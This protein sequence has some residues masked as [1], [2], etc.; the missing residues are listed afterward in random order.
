M[1]PTVTDRPAAASALDALSPLDGR[2]ADKCA[3]L[4]ALLSESALIRHRVRIEAEWLLFLARDLKLP[5]LAQL[6]PAVLKRASALAA[7]RRR[8]RPRRSRPRRSASPTT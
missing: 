5:E 1:R 7:A 3:P 8:A 6:A 2:Y 4:R